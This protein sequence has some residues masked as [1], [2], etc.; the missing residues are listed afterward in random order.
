[1]DEI[2]PKTI[3][4][5]SPF[6]DILFYLLI[7]V[8]I[9]MVG[10]YGYLI[11]AEKNTR[12]VLENLE[13]T[14]DEEKT[15]EEVVLEEEMLVMQKRL[16]DFSVLFSNHQSAQALF[17]LLEGSCHPRVWFSSLRFDFREFRLGLR[18]RAANFQAT[19]QQVIIFQNI[20]DVLWV[21]LSNLSVRKDGEVDFGL[22][23]ALNPELFKFKSF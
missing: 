7:M 1:M 20:S 21:N 9:V 22:D 18:C 6:L 12:V 17:D 8:I 19:E 16:K 14:L 4:K 3:V 23:L 13:Q 10:I 2:I 15:S 11:N 5:Q